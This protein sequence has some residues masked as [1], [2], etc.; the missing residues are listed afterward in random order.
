MNHIWAISNKNTYTCEKSV[1]EI[2]VD[3]RVNIEDNFFHIL[4][5]FT[6]KKSTGTK[7]DF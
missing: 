2:H 5:F 7:T 3:E 6:R 1:I 4:S